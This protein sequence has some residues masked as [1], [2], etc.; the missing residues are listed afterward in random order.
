MEEAPKITTTEEDEIVNKVIQKYEKELKKL[1][2]YKFSY[3]GVDTSSRIIIFIL[4]SIWILI[5]LLLNVQKTLVG[6][7]IIGVGVFYSLLSLFRP[8]I[9]TKINSNFGLLLIGFPLY[10]WLDKR[11]AGNVEYVARIFFSIGIF[12]SASM[13]EYP[14]EYEKSGLIRNITTV[15]T[16]L[17]VLYVLYDLSIN[18]T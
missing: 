13:I 7:L 5:T 9:I 16:V 15:Y 4:L 11:Y 10:I 1:K 3:T 17:L 8:L 14:M 2:S 12:A 18:I 6:S